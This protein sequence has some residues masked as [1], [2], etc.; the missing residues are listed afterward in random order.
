MRVLE[1]V[2]VTLD[3]ARNVRDSW[4]RSTRQHNIEATRSALS[5]PNLSKSRFALIA[6]SS[7]TVI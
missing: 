4:V 3:V 6:V 2:S 7:S 5:K 1:E